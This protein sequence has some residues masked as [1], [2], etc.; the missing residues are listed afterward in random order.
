MACSCLRELPKDG[1]E[2]R[3]T[4]FQIDPANLQLDKAT[5]R[6]ATNSKGTVKQLERTGRVTRKKQVTKAR[7]FH[8]KT[9]SVQQ[10][11]LPVNATV[12]STTAELLSFAVFKV[13]THQTP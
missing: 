8:L 10:E 13:V 7:N 11:N 6:T 12:V 4:I 9:F 1:A 3:E 2:F 5:Q